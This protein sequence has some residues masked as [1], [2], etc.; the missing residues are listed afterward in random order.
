MTLYNYAIEE[1]SSQIGASRRVWPIANDG[2]TQD[3]GREGVG[4]LAPAQI[5]YP[6]VELGDTHLQGDSSALRP[7]L[8]CPSILV[9][10]LSAQFCFG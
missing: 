7:W 4:A 1:Q 3:V 6:H 9:A 5:N 10:P 8:G 2:Q